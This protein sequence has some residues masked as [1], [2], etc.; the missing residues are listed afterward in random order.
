MI[1]GPPCP[2]R[3]R[4]RPHAGPPGR[5]TPGFS[6]ADSKIPQ[7]HHAAVT[8]RGQELAIRAERHRTSPAPKG[9]VERSLVLRGDD[10]PKHHGLPEL[11]AVLSG[12]GQQLAVRTEGN[13]I[14]R[15]MLPRRLS[16]LLVGSD[17]P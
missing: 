2:A 9:A 1:R 3:K 11:V 5:S 15:G 10:V 6:R 8:P 4:A 16:L 13:G 7:P 17:I 12:G 14:H